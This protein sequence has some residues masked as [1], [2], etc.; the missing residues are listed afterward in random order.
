M[1]IRSQI[2]PSENELAPLSWPSIREK[3]MKISDREMSMN[4]TFCNFE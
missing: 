2:Y 1:I 3:R 4:V